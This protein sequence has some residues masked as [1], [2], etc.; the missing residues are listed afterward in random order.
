MN[1]TLSD[2]NENY[3][4]QKFS[5]YHTADSKPINYEINFANQHLQNEPIYL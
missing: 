3:I 4:T 2:V 1:L 5:L